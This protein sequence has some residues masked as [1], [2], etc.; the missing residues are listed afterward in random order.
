MLLLP[1]RVEDAEVDRLPAVSIG[2]AVA[3]A[4]AFLFTWVLPGN[5]DGF[6]TEGFREI[7]R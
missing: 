7:A 2:I 5:P 1:V 4:V 6:R 3:C